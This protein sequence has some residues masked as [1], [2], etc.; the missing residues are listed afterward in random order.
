M[1]LKNNDDNNYNNGYSSYDNSYNNDYNNNYYNSYNQNYNQ[2]YNQG[3]GNAGNQAAYYQN[4]YV[5]QDEVTPQSYNMII[6]A[7]LLYGFVV[8]IIMIAT[9][10]DF[11]A[12][13]NPVVFYVLYFGMAL[14][15]GLMVHR[16]DNPVISFIGYNLYV[17]PLGMVLTL[18]INML[19]GYG[20]ESMIITAF[21]ITAI[22]TVVM[23]IL[24]AVFPSFFLSIGS[25][26]CISLLITVIVEIVLALLGINLG[27]ISYIVVLIFCGY[28]GYD[29]AKANAVPKT[30]DN[31]I[32]SAAEL[33]VDI[34][35]LFMRVLS[36]LARAN[37]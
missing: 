8:N 2:G 3:Y 4:T 6:G 9:C 21:A 17:L 27:I 23:M 31:A 12:N 29:W 19:L 14:A 18:T 11:V 10:Y 26:L 5:N 30:I 34:I 22:V 1:T 36:I 16:S 25:T 33:Y 7:T 28:I 32:D 37:D 35:A 20:Y 13:I 24:G 15:G